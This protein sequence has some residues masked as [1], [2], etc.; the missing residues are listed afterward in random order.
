M[1]YIYILPTI[2]LTQKVKSIAQLYSWLLVQVFLFSFFFLFLLLDFMCGCCPGLIESVVGVKFQPVQE[3]VVVFVFIFDFLIFCF[4][5]LFCLV[6]YLFF[7]L[8]VFFCN[9]HGKGKNPA[10]E[11]GN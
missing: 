2:R 10:R 7:G 5:L 1:F 3:I 8:F 11:K 4:R 6:W 9:P